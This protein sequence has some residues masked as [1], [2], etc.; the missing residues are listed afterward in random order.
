MGNTNFSCFRNK[1][2]QT[3]YTAVPNELLRDRR[4]TPETTWLIA[5]LLSHDPSFPI[6]IDL[7][8]GAKSYP[9]LH[10]ENKQ[11]RIPRTLGRDKLRQMVR[12]AEAAGY[13]IRLRINDPETGVFVW[14]FFAFGTPE[15]MD[16]WKLGH[17]FPDPIP[18]L[19]PDGRTLDGQFFYADIPDDVIAAD[20]SA[21]DQ[22]RRSVCARIEQ[23]RRELEKLDNYQ[24]DEDESKTIG[25]SQ[26]EHEHKKNSNNDKAIDG[27]PVDGKSVDGH[28]IYKETYLEET[29]TEED[30]SLTSPSDK[31]MEPE[32]KS[33]S[34]DEAIP[35]PL[36]DWAAS[37]KREY[38]CPEGIAEEDFYKRQNWHD[39]RT[40]HQ[41]LD[42]E[43]CILC[44]IAD[45]P[46]YPLDFFQFLEVL[47]FPHLYTLR[48][49]VKMPPNSRESLGQSIADTKGG[50]KG[51]NQHTAPSSET[52]ECLESPELTEVIECQ[53]QER[54]QDAEFVEVE[55]G[56]EREPGG[57]NFITLENDATAASSPDE[58]ADD[59]IQDLQNS[60]RKRAGVGDEVSLTDSEVRWLISAKQP[61]TLRSRRD[62]LIKK[63]QKRWK[64]MQQ[65]C[66]DTEIEALQALYNNKIPN[67]P[68]W[69]Q[70]QSVSSGTRDL[71]K[72]AIREIGF[73]AY[74][75]KFETA[76]NWLANDAHPSTKVSEDVAFWKWKCNSQQT[77]SKFIRYRIDDFYEKALHAQRIADGEITDGTGISADIEFGRKVFAGIQAIKGTQDD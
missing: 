76:I 19:P 61:R 15:R 2:P 29:Y 20:T 12:E 75:E 10:E 16:E 69:C 35:L 52:D 4:L 50:I 45:L 37:K 3:R 70:S 21:K 39:A 23:L 14:E 27:K 32:S 58:A 26:N 65:N 42:P 9:Y 8:R 43:R 28:Y 54:F 57:E 25:D 1:D 40:S 55:S 63:L 62:S 34:E 59:P 73:P 64:K 51:L 7:I 24:D 53:P 67:S 44:A 38:P 13:L 6:S 31:N 33:E 18:D 71:I 68:V 17:I 22:Q 72:K 56:R 66:G 30:I 74:R 49:P 47:E 36:E 46:P 48:Q 41:N 11:T 60:L 77:F 5:Y